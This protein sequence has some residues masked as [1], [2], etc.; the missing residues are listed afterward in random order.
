[1]IEVKKEVECK[2]DQLLKQM[3]AIEESLENRVDEEALII[4]NQ[5]KEYEDNLTIRFKE[6][7]TYVSSFENDFKEERNS[8][9]RKTKTLQL[10]SRFS[11]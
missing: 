9:V 4:V 8:Q 1:M 3:S 11:Y 10:Q 2:I 6:I 5:Y 7:D